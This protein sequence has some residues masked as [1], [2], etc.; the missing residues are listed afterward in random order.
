MAQD[1]TGRL[2]VVQGQRRVP[3]PKQEIPHRD[4]GRRTSLCRTVEL[5]V[6]IGDSFRNSPLSA[7]IRGRPSPPLGSGS[8]APK[9]PAGRTRHV[10]QVAGLEI[11][12]SIQYNTTQYNTPSRFYPPSFHL[13]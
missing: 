4:V 11:R 5:S 1:L 10:D 2:D 8:A 13:F 9:P 6:G 12:V 3:P 7:A